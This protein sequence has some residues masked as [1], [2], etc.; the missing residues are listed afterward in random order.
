MRFADKVAIV[1]GGTKNIGLTV[2][3]RL[4][5]AGDAAIAF[6]ASGD[7]SFTTAEPIMVSGGAF[8]RT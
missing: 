1:T 3:Q 2:A 4:C 8:C 7:T 5:D 6:L